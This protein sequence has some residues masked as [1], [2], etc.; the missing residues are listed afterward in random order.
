MDSENKE[1]QPKVQAD[2][3]SIAV[4]GINIGGDL[5]GNITICTYIHAMSGAQFSV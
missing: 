4:G 1:D 3:N 2:H 5:R